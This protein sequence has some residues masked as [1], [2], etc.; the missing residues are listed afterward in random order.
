M[1]IKDYVVIPARVGFFFY[2]RNN[3]KFREWPVYQFYVE[4]YKT[5]KNGDSGFTLLNKVAVFV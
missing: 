4:I 3:S 2:I 5:L 1:K